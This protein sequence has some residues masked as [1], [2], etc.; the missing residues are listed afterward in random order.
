MDGTVG[1]TSGVGAARAMVALPFEYLS[2]AGWAIC[3][4]AGLPLA[5]AGAAYLALKWW[6]SYGGW[7]LLLSLPVQRWPDFKKWESRTK[8]EL[9][10][11]AALW[12]DAEPRLP[13][14]WRARRKLRQWKPLIACGVIPVQN[15][16]L[17]RA[18]EVG[19]RPNSSIIPYILVHRETLKTLAEKEGRK[20]LFLFPEQRGWPERW[21]PTQPQLL[22]AARRNQRCERGTGRRGPRTWK[23]TQPP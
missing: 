21:S 10:E 19:T 17:G 3:F 11:V 9:H 6:R 16:R 13:M 2:P 20:P 22:S 8:F 14:W 23:G 1:A 5:L 7:P 15:Q 4:W 18:F 12:F